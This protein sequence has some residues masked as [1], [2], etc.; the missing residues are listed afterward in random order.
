MYVDAILVVGNSKE[1]DIQLGGMYGQSE[2]THDLATIPVRASRACRHKGF[3]LPEL[4]TATFIRYSLSGKSPVYSLVDKEDN[5]VSRKGSKRIPTVQSISA[6]L[7][8]SISSL[9]CSSIRLLRLQN[10]PEGTCPA[11]HPL[12]RLIC[13]IVLMPQC[14]FI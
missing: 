1:K 3:M 8:M 14:M 9:L 7:S 4:R 11:G 13:S 5:I 6:M 10:R 12:R 2:Q